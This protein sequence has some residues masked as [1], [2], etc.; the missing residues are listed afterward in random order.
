MMVIRENQIHVDLSKINYSVHMLSDREN[1]KRKLK[2]IPKME[3]QDA[4]W[5][6]KGHPNGPEIHLITKEAL[7][8]VINARTF[9]LCTVLV[10]RPGQIERYYN[11]INKSV[12]ERLIALAR[13]H[14]WIGENQI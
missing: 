14:Q 3:I 5:V 9:R 6:N 10:A 4:F 1:R 7:I 13:L 11:A 8:L 12:P 2:E